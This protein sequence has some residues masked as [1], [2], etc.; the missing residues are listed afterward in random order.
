MDP[1]TNLTEFL[2]ANN[3]ELPETAKAIGLYKPVLVVDRFCFT[4]GHLPLRRDGSLFLGTV[5]KEVDQDGGFQAARQCGL[6]MLASLKKTLGTLNRIQRVV[7]LLGMVNCAEG[8]TQQPAV[9]NGC[10]ELFA[11]VFGE[12]SGI[13]ARSAIGVN[14]LPLNV[15]VEVEGIFLLHEN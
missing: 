11:K 2:N 14:S 10:S 1:E 6:A 4:S 15:S 13:G 12:D 5:G 3:L 7:K 9:V 8:Y